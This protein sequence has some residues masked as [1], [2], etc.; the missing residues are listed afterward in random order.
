MHQE[1]PYIDPTSKAAGLQLSCPRFRQVSA[2][3]LA[4]GPS[5]TDGPSSSS[6]PCMLSRTY[7]LQCLESQPPT[8]KFSGRVRA[9]MSEV[10]GCCSVLGNNP[11]LSGVLSVVNEKSLAIVVV[12]GVVFVRSTISNANMLRLSGSQV[13]AQDLY[14]S[15]RNVWVSYPNL[16]RINLNFTKLTPLQLIWKLESRNLS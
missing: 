5:L 16:L 11:S 12:L 2:G 4:G 3:P 6:P 13:C 10:V 1:L 7:N 8:Q 15:W 14:L 9:C